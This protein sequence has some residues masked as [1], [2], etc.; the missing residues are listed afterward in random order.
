MASD[1]IYILLIYLALPCIVGAIGYIMKSMTERLRNL[2]IAVH[3]RVDEDKVRQVVNDRIDPMREDIREIR[4]DIHS[5]TEKFDRVV[6]ILLEK[7]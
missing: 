5:L 4:D 2:E 1:P 7:K 6:N 3:T